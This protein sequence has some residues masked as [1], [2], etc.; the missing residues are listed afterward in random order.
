[1]SI[2]FGLISLAN[3]GLFRIECILYYIILYYMGCTD[4]NI[5]GAE[6]VATTTMQGHGCLTGPAPNPA[7]VYSS[8]SSSTSAYYKTYTESC[9]D[10][11]DNKRTETS[12]RGANRTSIYTYDVDENGEIIITNNI[13]GGGSAVTTFKIE[14][15]ND[16]DERLERSYTTVN[17]VAASVTSIYTENGVIDAQSCSGEECNEHPF[18]CEGHPDCLVGGPTC[19][20]C[21]GGCTGRCTGAMECGGRSGRNCRCAPG[22]RQFHRGPLGRTLWSAY[23]WPVAQCAAGPNRAHRRR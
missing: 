22:G 2:I 18:N 13:N 6:A 11:G 8:L 17:N 15:G 1:L 14:Q 9:D 23:R 19:N 4:L 16:T 20:G 3:I 7:K 5:W 10:G 12:T 21:T